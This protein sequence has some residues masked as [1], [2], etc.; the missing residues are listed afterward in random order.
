M[1]EQINDNVINLSLIMTNAHNP[2][3]HL[4]VYAFL[5]QWVRRCK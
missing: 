5:K 4:I 2:L 1:N 3:T